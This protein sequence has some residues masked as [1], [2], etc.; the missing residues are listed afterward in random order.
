MNSKVYS[1]K[2]KYF[3]HLKIRDQ[4]ID[5]SEKGVEKTEICI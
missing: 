2:E 1:M 5:L 3:N 4:N